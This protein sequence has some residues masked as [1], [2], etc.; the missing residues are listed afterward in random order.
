MLRRVSAAKKKM[1]HNSVAIEHLKAWLL[2]QALKKSTSNRMSGLLHE[3][4][5]VIQQLQ[6]AQRWHNPKKR[7]PDPDVGVLAIVS[8][9][10][11]P[12]ITLDRAYCIA[13]YIPD[14][15]WI[16]SEYPECTN[17]EILAWVP[18]PEMP[19]S[20]KRQVE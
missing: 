12:N 6:A 9:K 1:T 19:E 18:L 4:Y 8:G 5:E 13:E 10:P 14:E 7:L 3:A 2:E 20:M 17:L 15:G 11:H 16:V